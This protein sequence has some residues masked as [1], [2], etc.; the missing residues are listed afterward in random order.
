MLQRLHNV[1]GFKFNFIFQNLCEINIFKKY[2][3]VIIQYT[4]QQYWLSPASVG[5]FT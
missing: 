3:K 4:I 5:C 2:A 1:S